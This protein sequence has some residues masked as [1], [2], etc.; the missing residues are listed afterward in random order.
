MA[1]FSGEPHHAYRIG[2]PAA[3]RWREVINTDAEDYGGSGVGNLGM[4][5]AIE[6]PW[7]GRPASAVLTLPPLG[8]LF[9]GE[10][11]RHRSP[12]WSGHRLDPGLDEP[13]GLDPQHP[14]GAVRLPAP[15]SGRARVEDAKP[16][17]CLVERNMRMPVHHQ[18][19]AAETG[20]A[21][22]PACP[23]ASPLSWIIATGRP[24]RSS[25]SA[26][27]A[28]QAATSGPSLL[29]STARTGA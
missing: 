4:I 6:E 13:P 7:H 22:G 8:V 23:V 15:V 26:G 27:G 28:P 5:E 14:D 18:A 16:L 21:A 19:G 3:G 12:S 25:S 2:L 9:L 1:N 29:P 10:A 24:S 11:A 20:G 17:V